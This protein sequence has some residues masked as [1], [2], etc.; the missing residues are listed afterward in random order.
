MTGIVTGTFTDVRDGKTYK[1]IKIGNQIWMAENLSYNPGNGSWAYDN[2]SSNEAI[3]GRLYNWETA[4]TV[5]P[6]GWHLPNDDEWIELTDYLGGKEVAGGK[7]KEIGEIHWLSPN[8]GAT[9]ENGFT[10]LPG[11]YRNYNGKFFDIGY[12]GY[13]WSTTEDSNYAWPRLVSYNDIN[14]LRSTNY[15]EEGFSIRCV[16]D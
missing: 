12:G 16:K 15:K 10:A 5:C 6:S 1:T 8:R 7:L 11:G 3:Y 13:F 14:V 9:N 2:N 4:K